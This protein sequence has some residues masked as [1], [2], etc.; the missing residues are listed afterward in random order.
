MVVIDGD[1]VTAK[2]TVVFD[3]SEYDVRYGS[4]SFFDDLG[5]Q[6]IYD[7]IALGV[8]LVANK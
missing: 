4:G 2:A 6:V 3:R 1:I 5:D 8:E 7:D